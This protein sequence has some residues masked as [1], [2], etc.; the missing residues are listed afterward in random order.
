MFRRADTVIVILL[1]VFFHQQMSM[2]E[3]RNVTRL[4][5]RNYKSVYSRHTITFTNYK[6]KQQCT[7]STQLY[8][9]INNHTQGKTQPHMHTLPHT[10]MGTNTHT[11]TRMHTRMHSCSKLQ[12]WGI[13]DLLDAGIEKVSL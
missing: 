7:Y 10:R 13:M 4:N 5:S 12:C 1:D 6:E 2:R 11:H 3:A 8:I 9:Y